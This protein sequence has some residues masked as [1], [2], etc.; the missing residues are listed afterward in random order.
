MDVGLTVAFAGGA[1]SLISPC[2]ALLLPAYFASTAGTGPR[3]LA[4]SVVFYSGLLATLL[5]VGLG[6]GALGRIFAEHRSAVVDVTA[7]VLVV[8]GIVALFGGGLDFA[9]RLPG[10]DRVRAAAQ[11]RTGIARSLL[12]GSAAGAASACT[13]PILG[14][15]LTLAAASGAVVEAGLL[16]AVYGAG[17]VVPMLLV[18]IV[19]QRFGQRG[20]TL[21]HGREFTVAGRTWHTTSVVTGLLLIAAGAA[22]WL[23][24]GFVGVADPATGGT[25]ARLQ[26]AAE[27]LARPS[28]DIALIVAAVAAVVVWWWR[29]QRRPD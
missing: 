13:G 5:P 11:S 1:L 24:D 29:G 15:V 3:L 28:L 9:G 10:L 20:R 4:H 21:L 23:T 14:A 8:F 6:V 18:A 27:S 19:W 25:A 22:Y 12:L 26:D 7:V 17:I 2:S 16:L